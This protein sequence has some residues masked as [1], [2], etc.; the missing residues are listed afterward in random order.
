[1]YFICF[2]YYNTALAENQWLN[3]KIRT[4]LFRRAGDRQFLHRIKE[5][6][7]FCGC[8]KNP[9]TKPKGCDIMIFGT[10]YGEGGVS[11][12]N[13]Q[14]KWV[15]IVVSNTGTLLSRVIGF[16]SKAEYNHA[17]LSL[18]PCMCEMYSFGRLNPYN[19]II[20]GFVME[21]PFFG[22]FKRFRNTSAVILRIPVTERQYALLKRHIRKMYAHKKR[23]FYNFVGLV[24]AAFGI[25]WT[26]RDWYYCSEFV[27]DTLDLFQILDKRDY[28]GIVKPEDFFRIPGKEIVYVGNLLAYAECQN[29]KQEEQ[30]VRRNLLEWND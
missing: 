5:P 11:E 7:E 14:G 18:D 28:D 23:Y 4:D 16:I 26:H 8:V 15:Y 20:G 1:M 19:P 3:G 17:S 10:R 22:T 21:S 30:L 2:I 9:L 29:H 27:R 25:C 12:M 6:M 13:E 24:F